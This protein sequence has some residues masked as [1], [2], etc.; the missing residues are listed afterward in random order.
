MTVPSVPMW[1]CPYCTAKV[2]VHDA[3]HS[4]I[5]HLLEQHLAELLHEK[6]IILRTRHPE[7]AR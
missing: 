2:E 6:P 7:P 5:D 4:P 1:P 3:F